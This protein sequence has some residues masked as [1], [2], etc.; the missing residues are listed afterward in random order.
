VPEQLRT[1]G[2]DLGSTTVKLVVME[3]RGIVRRE[4]ASAT[5]RPLDIARHFLESVPTGCAVMATGYG[6]DLLGSER[7]VPT[8][9]EIKAHAL[10]ARFLVPDCTAVL[11]IGG[12]D[13]KAISLDASGRVARFE[14]N[15]RCAAGTGKFLEVMAARLGFDLEQFAEA[16]AHGSNAVTISAMCTVFAESEVVGLLNRGVSRQ[17]IARGLHRSVAKRTAALYSRL[18]CAPGITAATGGGAASAVLVAML[19][20]TLGCTIRSSPDSQLAGAIGCALGAA[21]GKPGAG[22]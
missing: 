16:A 3:G 4:V 10:G 18:A 11:D 17:D 9:T 15:D 21:A 6:R 8:M 2:I 12:Q 19:E 5:S 20:E 7:E 22:T 14:M 13:L 1:A